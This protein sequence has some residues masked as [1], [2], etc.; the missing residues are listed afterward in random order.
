MIE[1]KDPQ[2]PEKRMSKDPAAV[3][4]LSI[5]QTAI[6][7]LQFLIVFVL[8]PGSTSAQPSAKDKPVQAVDSVGITV[9]DMERSV[10]FFSKVL[11]FEKVTDV[12]ISGRA[13]ETLQGLFGL[14]MRVVRM[15]L[16]NEFIV[17]SQYMAPPGGRPIP[18][19]SRSHDLWFQHIAI[20][21][22]DMAKAYR[23]LRQYR[24]KHV[25]TA[26]QVIPKS[27][28][29]AAGISAFKFRDPDDHN[30]ELLYFPPG[31]GDPRWQRKNKQLFL[32]I[33]H[34]AISISNTDASLKFYRDILGLTV[35]G[36]SLNSGIEQEHLDNLFGVK[37]RITGLR[38]G[39]RPPGIEFLEYLTPPG[40]RAMPVNTKAN[41]LWSWQTRLSVKDVYLAERRISKAGYQFVSSEVSNF[42]G[43]KLGFVKGLLILDP[44]SHRVLL[45]EKP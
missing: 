16:G 30:L 12:E 32:G 5:A 45:I 6:I 36:E 20:V 17:L 44:D 22:S 4:R 28:P 43:E 42:S 18:M 10:D 19:D 1:A 24:V 3:R 2:L 31:K 34:T 33:D 21:V 8:W 23:R 37:V 13:Y 35:M 15:R 26:P 25:S 39:P 38:P 40:R 27:N 41:D 7:C 11:S 14:R 9:S 29:A